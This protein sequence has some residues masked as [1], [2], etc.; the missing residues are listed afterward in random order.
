MNR[1]IVFGSR[2]WPLQYVGHMEQRLERLP[3]GTIVVHGACETGADYWAAILAGRLGFRIEAHPANW[4]ELGRAAGPRR[5][6][7]MAS[8]G[9]ALAIGF[10][11]PGI[12]KGTDNM[13][14]E[15]ELRGIPV[16]R[17]G[18]GWPQALLRAG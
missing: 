1:V 18:W 11:M 12:S 7:H 15:A 6:A 5:N 9:A 16:E 14:D 8:L 13:A 3:A 4:R 2:S 17:H 10:R